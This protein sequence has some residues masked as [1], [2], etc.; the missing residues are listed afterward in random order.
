MIFF[1]VIAFSCQAQQLNDTTF[2]KVY[3]QDAELDTSTQ[4]LDK[5]SK[6][7]PTAIT[8]IDVDGIKMYPNPASQFVVFELKMDASIP[9]YVYDSNGKMIACLHVRMGQNTLDLSRFKKGIY[10]V[11]MYTLPDQVVRKTLLVQ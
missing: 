3:F 6:D 10:H 9:V 8:S 7:L 1:G 2:S 5:V 4:L 11:A